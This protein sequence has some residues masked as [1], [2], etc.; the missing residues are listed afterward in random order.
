MTWKHL[1]FKTNEKPVVELDALDKGLEQVHLFDDDSIAA[2]NAA[3]AARRPLL[4]RGE[5]GTG[6]TQLARAAAKKLGWAFIPATVDARTEASELFY[7][8]DAVTRLGKAQAVAALG[9]KTASEVEGLLNEKNYVIPGELWWAFNWQS[10]QEQADLAKSETMALPD[11]GDPDEGRVLLIDEIDKADADLPNSLLEAFGAWQFRP[12]GFEGSVLREEKPI[13]V[14]IT[15]NEERALPDAFVRRCLVLHLAFEEN[16]LVDFFVKR[17]K[18]HF[19]KMTLPILKYAAEQVEKDRKRW[20]SEHPGVPAPGLAE[21]L[22][23]L[24]AVHDLSDGKAEKQKG[25]LDDIKH[26]A[27]DKHPKGPA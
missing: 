8:V 14:I 11:K 4:V 9:V 24:R 2:V 3:I 6:K 5:P 23:L 13:L 15:T 12:K 10:A 22:D 1:S 27:L 19:P 26:F 16:N 17:G 7:T 18:V 25:L 20:R 21:Y